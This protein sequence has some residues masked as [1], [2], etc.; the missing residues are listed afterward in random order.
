MD[1]KT[2]KKSD[3]AKPIITMPDM[4]YDLL[5][6]RIAKED[7]LGFLPRKLKGDLAAIALLEIAQSQVSKNLCRCSSELHQISSYRVLSLAN[8]SG[9][10]IIPSNAGFFEISNKNNE[11]GIIVDEI[12][13]GIITTLLSF[14]EMIKAFNQEDEIVNAGFYRC[15][16]N[17]L[18]Q[19]LSD[20]SNFI[21]TQPMDAPPSSEE[22]A[23]IESML[24]TVYSFT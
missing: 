15:F 21:L 10:L 16:R 13:F 24:E 17:N 14:D 23:Q 6:E 7:A 11:S 4:V 20:V 3:T 8:T 1:A 9:F 18:T 5:V 22:A 2:T 12:I 19:R